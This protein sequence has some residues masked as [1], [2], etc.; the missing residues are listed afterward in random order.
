MRGFGLLM[1]KFPFP[2]KPFSFSLFFKVRKMYRLSHI[3]GV[4]IY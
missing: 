3:S 4:L 1:T 2:R